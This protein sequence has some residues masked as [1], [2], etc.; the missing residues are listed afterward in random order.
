MFAQ[1]QPPAELDDDPRVTAARAS[2]C[3]PLYHEAV[4][5]VGRRWT[6]A[7]LR[8]L[9]DGPL[10]FSEIAQAVPELS[11]RLLSERMKELE[12]R[13]MVQRTVIS[14]PPLRVEYSLSRMGRELEPAL[15]ELQRWARRWLGRRAQAR[16]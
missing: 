11:D 10:R 15:S 12:A 3:C 14:G 9:M 4:E 5:L 13:G 8:V 6:G 2:G 7:I 1:E 16:V